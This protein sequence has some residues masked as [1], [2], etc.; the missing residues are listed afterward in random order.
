M[1]RPAVFYEEAYLTKSAAAGEQLER[2]E[3]DTPF[4][5]CDD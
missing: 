5:D 2:G 4:A 1:N 3:H